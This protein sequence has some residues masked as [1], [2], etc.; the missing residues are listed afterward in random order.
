MHVPGGDSAQGVNA[1]TPA[2]LH[3]GQGFL[4]LPVMH[5]Q[6][7]SE[8]GAFIHDVSVRDREKVLFWVVY[9]LSCFKQD[10]L[11]LKSQAARCHQSDLRGQRRLLVAMGNLY[12]IK[13]YR[14]CLTSS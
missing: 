4:F 11:V 1:E 9:A 12:V 7:V 13:H 6:K 14:C 3:H 2:Q 5:W 10:N 8:S